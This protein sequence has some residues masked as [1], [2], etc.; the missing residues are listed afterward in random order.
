MRSKCQLF[1][2]LYFAILVF[3]S[4]NVRQAALTAVFM[5]GPESMQ[6]VWKKCDGLLKMQSG[7]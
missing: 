1:C 3:V 4:P 6:H 5:I 2:F 7:M